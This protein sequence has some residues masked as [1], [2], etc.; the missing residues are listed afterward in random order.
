MI[1]VSLLITLT[2]AGIAITVSYSVTEEMEWVAAKL[3]AFFCLVFSIFLI[4][5]LLKLIILGFLLINYR[6]IYDFSL[7][8]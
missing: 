2:M 1:S 8:D 4:P 7:K 3:I 5:L 6:Y